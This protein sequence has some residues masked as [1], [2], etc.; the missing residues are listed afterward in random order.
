MSGL[1][2]MAGR[3][4]SCWTCNPKLNPMSAGP[5]GHSTA[6]HGP[7]YRVQHSAAQHSTIQ[8]R[9]GKMHS[10][11]A[12]RGTIGPKRLFSTYVRHI[13]ATALSYKSYGSWQERSTDSLRSWHVT[14]AIRLSRCRNR[15]TTQR[16]CT[17]Q[18]L[19]KSS[20]G[21][22]SLTALCGYHAIAC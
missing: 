21:S 2:I 15:S 11:C 16:T 13:P 1:A 3:S 18:P 10:M 9:S 22:A 5:A 17:M 6:Q 20:R 12:Q 8:L 19:L 4:K 14:P 7:Q